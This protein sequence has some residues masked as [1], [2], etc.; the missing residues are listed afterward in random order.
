MGLQFQIF[1]CTS[2]SIQN[3][4]QNFMRKL[5]K[6]GCTNADRVDPTNFKCKNSLD[7]FLP[8]VEL[9]FTWMIAVQLFSDLELCLDSLHII[10]FIGA[11]IHIYHKFVTVIC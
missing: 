6:M 5:K 11:G 7:S 9:L 2:V 8:I 10:S 3:D 1:L 4:N